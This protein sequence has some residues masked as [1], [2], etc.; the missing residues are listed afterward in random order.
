M[1]AVESK[2]IALGTQ[3]PQFTL[4]NTNPNYPVDNVSLSDFSESKGIVI[5]FICNHCPYVVHL[6]SVFSEFANRYQEHGIAVVAISANDV[7]THPM[8]SPEK[9]ALDAR[10]YKYK[11]PYLYDESQAVARAYG[12]ECTPDFYLFNSKREL[13]YR[14][15]FDDSRPSNGIEVTGTHLHAAVTAILTDQPVSSRQKPS[16]GCSIKW[17]AGSR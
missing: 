4:P 8:D 17:K 9:M 12:A 1:P 10:Q 13:F 15:Q 16:I 7:T 6:K 5:A 11:F 14:G 3:A 2:M